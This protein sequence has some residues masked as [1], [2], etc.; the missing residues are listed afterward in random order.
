M[1][2]NQIL[3]T[4]PIGRVLLL[5][6]FLG[7]GW[8]A[9][10]V[11]AQI[12]PDES[13]RNES[14]RPTQSEDSRGL[15]TVLIEGGA[16]RG[17]NLFQSF[18]DFNVGQGQ[19]VYFANPVGVSS[20][21]SRVTGANPS[22][23]F[24]TLGVNGAANLFLLN[25]RGILFGPDARLDVAGSFVASTA[26]SFQFGNALQF[27][28]TRPNAAPMLTIAVQPG[29]QYG[30]AYQGDI[31]NRARLQVDTGQTL[32]LAGNTVIHTG[33]LVAPAGMVQVLGNSIQLVE[34]ARID[35]SGWNGGGTALIGGDFQGK[36]LLPNATRTV[37]GPDV[38]IFA[39][40]QGMGPG[41]RV[42]VW[43]DDSTQFAGK[44]S[45]RGGNLGGDGGFVEVSGKE[46]LAFTGQ[47]NA[48]AVNGQPGTLFL[49]PRDIT[50]TVENVDALLYNSAATGTNIILDATNNI[51]FNTPINITAFDIDLTATA[52]NDIF[53]NQDI[54]TNAGDLT[55]TAGGGIFMRDVTLDTNPL[56]ATFS[57]D[58]RLTAG[59]RVEVRD[60]T[61][62]VRSDNP[63]TNRFSLVAMSGESVLIDRSYI[64]TTNINTG[65]AGD[66]AIT[67]R[68]RVDILNSKPNTSGNQ[69][70]FSRGQAGRIFIGESL[71]FPNSPRVIRIDNSRLSTD[72]DTP[73][74]GRL[75]VGRIS[76]RAEDSIVLNNRTSILS[77]TFKL[78][79]AGDITLET[80]GGT[81]AMDDH[82]TVF[83]TVERQGVGDGGTIEIT[84]GQLSLT[85]SSELQ[86]QIETGGQ[87]DAGTILVF[88][89]ES[90][91]LSNRSGIFSSVDPGGVGNGGGVG[92]VS[93]SLRM[94]GR[95]RI[96]TGTY[97]SGTA[98]SPNTTNGLDTS[99]TGV[100]A[101][102]SAGVVLLIV[103]DTVLDNSNIFNNLEQGATGTAGAILVLGDSLSLLNGSQVQ[104]LVNAGANGNAGSILMGLTGT[105]RIK[106]PNPEGNGSAIISRIEQGGAG[107]G[108]EV[109]LLSKSLQLR[110]SGFITV[111][112]L[113][114]S[115]EAGD[116]AIVAEAIWLDNQARIF[117][118]NALGQGG[119]VILNTNSLIIGRDSLISTTSGGSTQGTGGNIAVGRGVLQLLPAQRQNGQ[120]VIAPAFPDRTLVVAGKTARDNNI[121]SE[122]FGGTGGNIHINAFRLQ[123]IAERQDLPIR[124]DISTESF[125]GISGTTVLNIF[126]IFPPLRDDP[127]PDRAEIPRVQVG[128]DSRT[129]QETSSL[130]VTGRGSLA[131]ASPYILC[132]AIDLAFSND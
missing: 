131:D 103:N 21:F 69:G 97:S 99:R 115:G 32:S 114:T 86:S 72:N 39:D 94:T 95:S 5:A 119:N 20:I 113:G 45:A 77:S 24:G 62:D 4:R 76:L 83:S 38:Q 129:R 116:I 11:Y 117:S 46:S 42:I 61:I 36:R 68:N 118:A 93:P 127:L 56:F 104:T 125:L 102:T 8:D 122:A 51:R 82:S 54:R 7:S 132:Q 92:I 85:N 49:D 126:D 3:G 80:N 74:N 44:I 1:T 100:D 26:D 120:T 18:R 71:Y 67:A 65:L 25:P 13:L 28:A 60:S 88:A 50:V 124:N 57:G 59:G 96:S 53:I 112:N 101:L 55:F 43:A 58:V 81:I 111:S 23:I 15:T 79:D 87:G 9:G 66:V 75:D 70:I 130:V 10:S 22:Q 33:E 31:T 91:S 29:L 106:G 110:D 84:T 52:G 17:E 121:L 19:R 12:V 107:N 78:G 40:A 63:G 109:I 105:I 123:D 41:G 90:V 37:V 73:A 47:V 14:A 64:T 2:Q 108:G 35:V 6:I 98:S 34:S 30:T 16:R 48:G 27:S 89:T 128:C